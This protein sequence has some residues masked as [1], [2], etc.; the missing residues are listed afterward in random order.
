MMHLVYSLAYALSSAAMSSF[1][2]DNI[3]FMTR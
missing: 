1:F 2:I 3:A